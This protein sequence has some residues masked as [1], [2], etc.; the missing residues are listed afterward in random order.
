MSISPLATRSRSS[1]IESGGVRSATGSSS[2]GQPRAIRYGVGPLIGKRNP[3]RGEEDRLGGR[4]GEPD[5]GRTGP[6]CG[7]YGPGTASRRRWSRSSSC[8]ASVWCRRVNG[9]RPSGSWPSGWGSAGSPCARC[10]RSS[11]TR[12]WWRAGAAGTAARSCWPDAA[13]GGED[14]LRRRVAGVDVEDVLRFRE[15]LEVGAAGLCAAHGLTE[16]G[17][18]AAARG[19][20]RD[21]RRRA[22]RLPPPGH[23]APPDPRRAVRIAHADRPVRGGPGHRQRPAG[24]HPAPGAQPGALPAPAHRAG[25]GG[26]RRRRGRRARGDAGALRGD[27]GAAARTS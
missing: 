24:L 7:P 10:S 22:L 2:L 23:P 18:R 8:S 12:A 27:G 3:R 9:C 21:P 26:A 17:R 14:E 1:S 5:A 19:A 4:R 11:R 20:G 16:R 15:V 6:S 13:E 25:R